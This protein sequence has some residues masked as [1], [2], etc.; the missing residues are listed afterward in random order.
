MATFVIWCLA[1]GAY[2]LFAGTLSLDELIT[3]AVLATLAAAWART[4]SACSWQ[5]F[6]AAREQIMP[7]VRALGGVFP[8]T[9][10]TFA[11][12]LAVVVRGSSPGRAMATRFSFGLAEDPR[13]RSRRAIAVLCAS[14]APDRFVVNVERARAE[15]LIHGIEPG[16]RELDPGWLE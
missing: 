15:A 9:L 4:I 11:I 16:G 10:R 2:L 13:Q 8:A 12:L 5:R 3:G 7:V 14:L 1:F 6:A